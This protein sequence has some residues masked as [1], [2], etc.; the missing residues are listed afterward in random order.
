MQ[1]IYVFVGDVV[2]EQSLGQ[3]IVHTIIGILFSLVFAAVVK[4]AGKTL[5]LVFGTNKPRQFLTEEQKQCAKELHEQQLDKSEAD[6]AAK[7]GGICLLIYKNLRL[8]T[9]TN[10]TFGGLFSLFG[11]TTIRYVNTT[12]NAGNSETVL[13]CVK[14]AG[15]EITAGGV[16]LWSE[17]RITTEEWKFLNACALRRH[18]WLSTHFTKVEQQ[19]K[20]DRI[21]S[22]VGSMSSVK[23]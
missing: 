13:Y 10:P 6:I 17:G 12:S 18:E 16:E 21:A 3:M 14:G 19:Q 15:R 7:F 20:N 22:A 9:R 5:R 2:G 4:I 23:A 8:I 1:P 11:L